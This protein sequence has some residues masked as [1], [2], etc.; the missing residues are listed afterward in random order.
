MEKRVLDGTNLAGKTV[1]D[2]TNPIAEAP[3]VNGVLSFFTGPNASL[4]EELQ[5]LGK[6]P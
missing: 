4:L 2:T 5:R 1:I 3:P 6:L